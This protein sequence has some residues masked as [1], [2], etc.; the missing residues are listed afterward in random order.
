MERT[1]SVRNNGLEISESIH[2]MF[3]LLYQTG[4]SDKAL[5]SSARIAAPLYTGKVK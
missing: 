1:S 5:S 4:M 3:S 2:A